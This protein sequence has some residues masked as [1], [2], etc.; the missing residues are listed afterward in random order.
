MVLNY[1]L[2][3]CPWPIRH[4]ALHFRDQRGTASFRCRNH[5]KI[6]VLVCEQKPSVSGMVLVPVKKLSGTVN[7]LTLFFKPLAMIQERSPGA[8]PTPLIFGRMPKPHGW[9]KGILRLSFGNFIVKAAPLTLPLAYSGCIF[10]KFVKSRCRISWT[11][12]LTNKFPQSLGTSLNRGSTVHRFAP[13]FGLFWRWS[14]KTPSIR[15]TVSS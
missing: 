3:G 5:A 6:T 7:S 9:G 15:V 1:I 11:L 8:T 13:I 4:M 14:F 2:V 10:R 12:D